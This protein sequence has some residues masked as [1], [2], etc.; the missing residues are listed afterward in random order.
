M[1]S[2]DE[3][4]NKLFNYF[5]ENKK[6]PNKIKDSILEVKLK[7]NKNIIY[8][9][10]IQKI[11]VAII[12]LIAIFTGA[13]Y[14]NDIYQFA[15]NLFNDNKGVNTAVENGYVHN[16]L[17]S[18]YSE[19]N[20]TQTKIVNMLM[21][22]YTLDLNI[23][24][25]FDEGIDVTEI[26]NLEIPDILITDDKNNILFCSNTKV[27]EEYCIERNINIDKVTNIN[28][29]ASIFIAKANKT[30][31]SFTC[32]LSASEKKFPKSKEIFIKF[33]TIKLEGKTKKYII[34]GDWQ[35]KITVPDKFINRTSTLYKVIN[36]NNKN[37][38]K[39]SILA[40]VYETGMYFE[41]YMYWE[42]YETAFNKI[43]EMRKQSI[44]SGQLIK[45]EESYVENEKG[46]KFYPSQSSDSDGGYGIG[47]DNILIKWETF[48]LTKFDMTD[49]LKVV[50]KTIDNEEIII[51]LEK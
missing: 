36:C 4:D 49:K 7:R 15:K 31:M 28:T 23:V 32:N 41:M 45:Q 14:S 3:F 48:N 50:F 27:L 34:T 33:N 12:S 21:D 37:V 43:E 30:N 44:L 9:F 16:N 26:E 6:V 29:S 19:S 35:D 8:N 38:Y 17:E 24:T 18:V 46:T 42:D 11:A 1:I 40:E 25:L 20:N 13:V 2:N 51:E 22:D 10:S 39:D 5:Q 47:P